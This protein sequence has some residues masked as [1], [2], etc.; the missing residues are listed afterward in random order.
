MV[1]GVGDGVKLSEWMTTLPGPEIS[2]NLNLIHQIYKMSL[3]FQCLF[4][5]LE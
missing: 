1:E 4:K 2:R 5:M 3:N